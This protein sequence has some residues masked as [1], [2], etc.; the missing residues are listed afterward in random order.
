MLMCEP[1]ISSLIQR[2][3][4]N[5]GSICIPCRI[6][7]LDETI[8]S[9]GLTDKAAK[10]LRAWLTH[11]DQGYQLDAPIDE[12]LQRLTDDNLQQAGLKQLSQR[13]LVLAKLAH[14]GRLVAFKSTSAA[15]TAG[16]C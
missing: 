4:G 15:P 12:G 10:L 1:A 3:A 11:E 14:A 7:S 6:M 5:V 9:W 16:S 8:S 2:V 13:N